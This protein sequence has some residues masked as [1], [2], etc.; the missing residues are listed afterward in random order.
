MRRF[1]IKNDVMRRYK[2]DLGGQVITLEEMAIN[3][4]GAG[5]KKTSAGSGTS[6]NMFDIAIPNYVHAIAKHAFLNCK[7]IRSVYLSKGIKRIEADAFK[8]CT[9]LSLITIPDQSKIEGAIF[10][11]CMNLK[12][13]MASPK[14][15][16][17][18]YSFYS[19]I[20]NLFKNEELVFSAELT[21]D[22]LMNIKIRNKKAVLKQFI[23]C[24]N[25]E[26]LDFLL[27]KKFIANTKIRDELIEYA[28]LNQKTGTLTALLTYK[29]NTGNPVKEEKAREKKAARELNMS[30][31]QLRTRNLRKKWSVR[32]TTA[33][34]K[35]Y[36][37]CGYR[38]CE[39]DVEIPTEIAGIPITE[40]TKSV[41][42]ENARREMSKQ[43]IAFKELF[44]PFG[45]KKL[46]N[47]AF[48]GCRSLKRIS[49][50]EGITRITNGIFMDCSSLE[51]V[52][53]PDSITTIGF[54]AFEGCSSLKS[55]L[56]PKS[57]KIIENGA[58]SYCNNIREIAI[59]ERVTY[60]PSFTFFGCRNLKK[61][62]LSG[63]LQSISQ[64]VFSDCPDLI[65]S[66]PAG[67][68]AMHYAIV[69]QLPFD[70]IEKKEV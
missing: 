28:S 61:I 12:T 18:L 10:E 36:K 26:V 37:L 51:E 32:Y 2:R 31:E 59:P 1:T 3:M 4:S 11:G 13:V 41:F 58:F 48:A 35:A 56:L 14:K 68:Y 47:G 20:N 55:I 67:S 57:V 22:I 7:N 27:G 19:N 9:G 44:I 54:N 29:S 69:N 39:A 46:D 25:V 23:E 33:E 64:C 43:C 62:I 65:I 63:N 70:P 8:Q 17:E 6:P 24:D 5:N 16:T 21:Q 50:P 52:I 40:I 15:K 30:L 34:K 53:L 38:G 60:I 49:I 45:I 42:S 66:A